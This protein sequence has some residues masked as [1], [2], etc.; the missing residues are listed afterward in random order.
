[1]SRL[2]VLRIAVLL[3]FAIL[4]GRLYELQIGDIESTRSHDKSESLTQRYLPIRPL[5]GE[6]FASDG[7]TRLAE[8]LPIYTVAIRPADLDKAE[9]LAQQSDPHLRAKVF[10]H[11]SQL[12]G[13]T[14]TLTISP[15]VALEQNPALLKDLNEGLGAQVV[16]SA[17]P[18]TVEVPLQL[19]IRPSQSAN[20]VEL[21]QHHSRELHFE[22]DVAFKRASN[23]DQPAFDVALAEFSSILQ[24]TGTLTISPATSIQTNQE[25]RDDIRRLLGAAALDAAGEPQVRSWKTV[26]IRADQSMEALKLSEIYSAS[27]ILNNP[28]DD[29]LQRANIPAYQTVLIQ[30]NIPRNVALVLREN[31]NDLPGVVV[32]QD[33]RRR[34]PLSSAIP[35]LSHILGYTGRID[36]C[37]LVEQNPAR[38]WSLGLFDSIGHV[39]ACGSVIPKTINPLSLGQVRYLDNDRIGKDGIDAS[40]EDQLRG[41]LGTEQLVVD[42]FNRPVSAPETLQRAHDGNNLILTID[43][44][45]QQQVEQILKNWID[46][47]EQLR[48]S[49]SGPFAWKRNYQPIRSGAAIVMEVHTGRILA[50]VSWPSYDNNIWVD[51]T[52]TKELQ[53]T[54]TSP[55]ELGILTDR[56]ISG[57]YPSGSTLKQFDAAIALQEGLITPNTVLDDHGKLVVQNR[58]GGPPSVYPNAG[59][60]PYNKIDV[61]GALLHSSNV[62]FMSVMGGNTDVS[63]IP[64]DERVF[65]GLQPSKFAEGLSWFGFG[66]PTGIDLPNEAKGRVPTPAWKAQALQQPWTTGDTYNMAIGQGNLIVTPLQLVTAA[67]AVADNGTVYRPQLVKTITDINGKVVREIQPEVMQKVPIDPSYFA[68]VRQGMRRSVTEGVNIAA[69]DQCSGLQI[70]G[71]TGTAEFGPEIVPGDNSTRQTHSWFVGFAPYDNPQIEVVVLSEG[72]GSLGDGSARIAVPAVTQIMQ[73]YFNT[74]PPNPLPPSC[75]QGLPPLPPRTTPI[76]ATNSPVGR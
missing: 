64:S 75:Q 32:E 12:L 23:G 71:K 41:Q 48:L 17:Q 34:Y 59:N 63:N 19:P 36:R 51:P 29:K 39:A 21:L 53:A 30:E 69:R 31:A 14:S 11:L 37:Q 67:A 47:G 24:V 62:F 2:V 28:I 73:A 10:A 55:P 43:V 57:G 74:T 13:I 7:T 20:V 46:L 56:A 49:Q 72:T 42:A 33:Y 3:I 5:R 65:Q 35:S 18:Q 6:V 22:P 76:T 15:A 8:T 9:E 44:G 58:Y 1:M 70:A 60:T 52:R 61:E 54:L 25:L 16:A 50:M 38:S 26:D 68:V 4:V 40:Y 45:L 27:L 66:Q